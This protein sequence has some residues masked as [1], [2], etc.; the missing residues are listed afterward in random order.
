MKALILQIIVIVAI[1]V[2]C[3]KGIFFKYKIRKQ[4]EY[5][6]DIAKNIISINESTDKQ[7]QIITK[8]ELKLNDNLIGILEI[9]KLNLIA[10]VK[11]G[12]SQ[13]ILKDSIGHFSNSNMW[14][15][16]YCFSIT[17]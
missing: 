9:P 7:I 5:L 14:N 3:G 16:K 4:K 11:E 12:I 13:N 10:P 17:Q 2:F 8:E 15:R 1:I 6:L